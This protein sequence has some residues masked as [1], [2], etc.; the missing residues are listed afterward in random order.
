MSQINHKPQLSKICMVKKFASPILYLVKGVVLVYYHTA[1]LAE[2]LLAKVT[3]QTL[4]QAL[5]LLAVNTEIID[6]WGFKF[7]QLCQVC[8]PV[9]VFPFSKVIIL[10]LLIK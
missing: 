9:K 5:R 10:S 4:V 6:R 2:E 7:N 3:I 1:I 8:V